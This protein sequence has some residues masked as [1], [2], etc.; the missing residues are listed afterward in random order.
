MTNKETN[1]YEDDDE[2]YKVETYH[3][4]D[5]DNHDVRVNVV[6]MMMTMMEIRR[7]AM[8]IEFMKIKVLG[9]DVKRQ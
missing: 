4:G 5:L 3:D 2:D 7:M 6:V 1:D 9:G 8:I